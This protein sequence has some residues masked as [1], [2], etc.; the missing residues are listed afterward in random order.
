MKYIHYE[1]VSTI[2]KEQQFRELMARYPG[3]AIPGKK[4]ER[5]VAR[6]AFYS[7]WFDGDVKKAAKTYR[8]SPRTI[9][10]WDAQRPSKNEIEQS[11]GTG[12]KTNTHNSKERKYHG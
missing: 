1:D 6:E 5:A 8:V 10:E 9:Y 3:F 12:R 4:A 2:L 11:I 7:Q